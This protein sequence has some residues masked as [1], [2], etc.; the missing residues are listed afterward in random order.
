MINCYFVIMNN[1]DDNI[2]EANSW[3][4][5]VGSFDMMEAPRLFTERQV[6]RL[7]TGVRSGRRY[8]LKALRP[9]LAEVEAYRALLRKEF[10]LANSLDHQGIVSVFSLERNP[11]A[12]ECIVMEYVDGTTLAEYLRTKPAKAERRRVAIELAEALSYLHS[13]GISHRD[14]K[15]DNLMITAHGHHLRIIDFGVGDADDFEML[16]ASGATEDFGAPEQLAGDGAI[17]GP[18]A[19]VWAYGA[20]L[21]RLSC[22]LPYRAI[23]S[24]CQRKRAER[25]PEMVDILRRVKRF[26]RFNAMSVVAVPAMLLAG[27]GVGFLIFGGGQ[28]RESL[29]TASQT[30]VIA[31]DDTTSVPIIETEE[32]NTPNTVNTHNKTVEATTLDNQILIDSLYNSAVAE[33]RNIIL[34][35]KANVI[36][37]QDAGFEELQ[38]A[39]RELNDSLNKLSNDFSDRLRKAGIPEYQV[40]DFDRNLYNKIA[41]LEEEAG[42]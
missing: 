33:A 27:V 4:G 7:Y 8:I 5:P 26:D 31:E 39:M 25:R 41:D 19:D 34:A 6:Y 9:E 38:T 3:S 36:S 12:G 29:E 42:L 28:S 32:I 1:Y 21:K 11:V 16:K 35:Q 23:A 15:P 30:A 24:R 13:R 18:S 22:G 37:A 20:I 10:Q 40:A 2:E 17:V 14:L